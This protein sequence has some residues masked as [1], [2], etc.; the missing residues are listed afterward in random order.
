MCCFFCLCSVLPAI[1][2]LPLFVQCTSWEGKKDNLPLEL[3]FPSISLLPFSFFINSAF[4]SLA[5]LMLRTHVYI[6][7]C[8]HTYTYH[9]IINGDGEFAATCFT[10]ASR[11]TPCAA[12]SLCALAKF[13]V[14]VL[15]AILWRDGC[16]QQ[17]AAK[18]ERFSP[19]FHGSHFLGAL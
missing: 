7:V 1:I 19:T 14:R 12:L 10:P 6:C 3:F 11:M 13:C 2:F 5:C 17:A 15:P 18:C 4:A 9:V 8:T 16:R